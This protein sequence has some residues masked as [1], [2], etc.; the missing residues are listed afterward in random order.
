MVE[1]QLLLPAGPVRVEGHNAW[2]ARGV[3]CSY[4]SRECCRD[5]VLHPAPAPSTYH[6]PSRGP[7]VRPPARQSQRAG[8][9]RAAR[10]V[11]GGLYGRPP[12]LQSLAGAASPRCPR[13]PAAGEALLEGI[14]VRLWP[15]GA[16]LL[17]QLRLGG[18]HGRG[19]AQSGCRLRLTDPA[20]Q[21]RASPLRGAMQLLRGW[22]GRQY[23]SSFSTARPSAVRPSSR[24]AGRAAPPPQTARRRAGAPTRSGAAAVPWMGPSPP[25]GWW[26]RRAWCWVP[27][28]RTRLGLV[29]RHSR[30]PHF[31][32]VVGCRLGTAT[33]VDEVAPGQASYNSL[34]LWRS[35]NGAKVRV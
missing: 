19:P 32:H 12:L 16:Q 5:A 13:H 33:F 25:G 31:S 14:Q 7:S 10:S 34:R 28:C 15:C 6:L 20:V 11:R 18:G 30:N 35:W 23:L 17:G 26:R 8:R 9:E 1:D 27:P 2:P 29:C 24:Y 4:A 3:V 21:R 22:R